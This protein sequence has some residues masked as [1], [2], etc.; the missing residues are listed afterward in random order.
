MHFCQQNRRVPFYQLWPRTAVMI[1]IC[2][3]EY[4]LNFIGIMCIF[5]SISNFWLL[6]ILNGWVC[7]FLYGLFILRHSVVSNSVTPWT[8][9]HQ[10]PLSMEFS[11]Q[12]YW[13]GLPCPPSGNL[14]NPGIKPGSPTLQ[15]ESL[16]S[17]PRGKA[18][19]MIKCCLNIQILISLLC[20]TLPIF[21]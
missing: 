8:V 11:R 16:P 20:F 7:Q 10:A 17:G 12:E 21:F 9:A 14:P 5:V 2:C 4:R 1:Q 18:V 19:F 15:A 6:L 13:S 3:C